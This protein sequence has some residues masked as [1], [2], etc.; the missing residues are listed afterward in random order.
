MQHN[1][2]LYWH[3]AHTL[4]LIKSQTSDTMYTKRCQEKSHWTVFVF[5]PHR[6]L[7][8]YHSIGC[9]TQYSLWFYTFFSL[10]SCNGSSL[11]LRPLSG[12]TCSVSWHKTIISILSLYTVWCQP[13]TVHPHFLC[14]LIYALRTSV[15]IYMRSICICSYTLIDS[16]N[17]NRFTFGIQAFFIGG[18]QGSMLSR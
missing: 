8:L 9:S 1:A 6:I 18:E 17:P 4:G 10:T 14:I 3:F 11:W 2:T 16:F 7:I 5:F 15:Y 12:N 13:T